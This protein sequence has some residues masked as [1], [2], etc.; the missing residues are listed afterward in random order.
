MIRVGITGS[1]HYINQIKIGEFIKKLKS[2]FGP[3]VTIVSGGYG[4]V[5][6]A[7]KEYALEFG[8]GYS[9]Y[10]PSFTGYNEYS[11]L[12]QSYYGKNEHISHLPNRYSHMYNEVDKMLLFISPDSSVDADLKHLIKRLKKGE[13]SWKI[14]M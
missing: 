4:D 2:T 12:H 7:V 5:D 14:I 10:N 3:T 1:K 6:S 9:E 8:L 13:I 11:A